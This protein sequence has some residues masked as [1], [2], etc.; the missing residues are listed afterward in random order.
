MDKVPSTVWQKVADYTD[1]S[2]HRQFIQSGG[3]SQNTFEVTDGRHTLY[4]AVGMDESQ[5]LGAWS[6]IGDIGGVQR[7]IERVD[8]DTLA[9]FDFTV[10]NGKVLDSTKTD[11]SPKGKASPTQQG[12]EGVKNTDPIIGA[13]G[14]GT[15]AKVK[16][17][18][19]N[20]V[21]TLKEHKLEAIGLSAVAGI[22]TGS[23][24]LWKKKRRY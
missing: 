3:T 1:K 22:I 13:T 11:A 24:V 20:V 15:Q 23:V 6:G 21:K 2:Q 4:V 9:K 10:K 19:D 7:P 18:W 12:G 5:G 17:M 8:F 16:E 14:V